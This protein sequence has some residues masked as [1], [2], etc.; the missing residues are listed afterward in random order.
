VLGPRGRDRVGGLEGVEDLEHVMAAVRVGLGGVQE[1]DDEGERVVRVDS[2]IDGLENR[3][4]PVPAR[5]DRKAV[6]SRRISRVSLEP[7]RTISP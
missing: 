1:G 6:C 3:N 2:G 7:Q 4:A 5:I